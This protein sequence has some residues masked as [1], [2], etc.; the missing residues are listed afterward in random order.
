MG[1]GEVMQDKL[2]G[3]TKK[4]RQEAEEELRSAAERDR[5][6]RAQKSLRKELTEPALDVARSQKGMVSTPRC[7]SV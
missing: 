7:S 1:K 5:G 3:A 2:D 4:A 6:A